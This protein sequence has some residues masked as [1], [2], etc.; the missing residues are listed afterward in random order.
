MTKNQYIQTHLNTNY[1]NSEHFCS[2]LKQI[3]NELDQSREDLHQLQ[4][5]F[6]IS[7]RQKVQLQL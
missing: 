3:L 5:K 7:E 1:Q 2:K 4:Q 6:Q